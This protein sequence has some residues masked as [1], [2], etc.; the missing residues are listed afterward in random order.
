MSEDEGTPYPSDGEDHSVAKGEMERKIVKDQ[1][2]TNSPVHHRRKA[3]LSS[4]TLFNHSKY[5]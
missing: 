3:S 4:S 1:E 5:Y 2:V